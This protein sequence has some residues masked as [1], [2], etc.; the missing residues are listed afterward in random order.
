MMTAPIPVKSKQAFLTGLR[1]KLILNHS[2]S[3][4]KT[5][6]IIKGSSTNKI[7][8]EIA[9]IAY[10][11]SRILLIN[12]YI[13][14][15]EIMIKISLY[16]FLFFKFITQINVIAYLSSIIRQIYLHFL[17]LFLRDGICCIMPDLTIICQV[18]SRSRSGQKK[19]YIPRKTDILLKISQSQTLS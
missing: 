12:A 19:I 2:R 15:S 18:L 5:L 17:Q 9:L 4:R 11:G 14:K 16:R 13:S 7:I 6:L 10:T 8:F 1:L 3:E